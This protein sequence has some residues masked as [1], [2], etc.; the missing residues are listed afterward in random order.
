LKRCGVARTQAGEEIRAIPP[1]AC[2][3]VRL[4]VIGLKLAAQ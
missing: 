1:K 4:V 3:A 2:A